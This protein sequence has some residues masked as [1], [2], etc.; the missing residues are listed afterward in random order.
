MASLHFSLRLT[1]LISF[2]S[3]SVPLQISQFS[4][5][6]IIIAYHVINIFDVL[7]KTDFSDSCLGNPSVHSNQS[8]ESRGW[9]HSSC[10]GL[11]NDPV[12]RRAVAH[13]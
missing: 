11:R 1:K 6:R 13:V 2:V 3:I 4:H 10:A 7:C 8:E 5:H 12:R 9:I